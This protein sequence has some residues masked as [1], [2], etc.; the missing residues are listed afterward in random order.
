MGSDNSIEM[1]RLQAFVSGAVQG[2]GYR[3][4]AMN[5]AHGLGVT[6]WVRNLY[7]GSVQVVAEGS[8]QDLEKFLQILRQGPHS[9]RVDEVRDSWFEYQGEFDRFEVRF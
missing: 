5:A 8:R 4:F 9:G 6:G 7:D 1:S 2:V 3:Y